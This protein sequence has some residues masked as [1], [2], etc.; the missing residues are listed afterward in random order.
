VA[1][2]GDLLLAKALDELGSDRITRAGEIVGDLP[3]VSPEQTAGERIDHRSDL[4]SLGATLYAL[5]TGRPPCEGFNTADTVLRIQTQRPDPPTKY[6]LAVPAIFEGVVMRLLAKRPDD[7]FADATQ[8]L[9]ELDRVEKYTKPV[10]SHEAP[11]DAT[12]V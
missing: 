9:N 6:H 3:Y 2:L 12:E 10:E 5:L 4:Y 8:L 1:K 11:P 7:R